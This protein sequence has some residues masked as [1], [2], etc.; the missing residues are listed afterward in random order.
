MFPLKDVIGYSSVWTQRFFIPLLCHAAAKSTE[1]QSG[2]DQEHLSIHMNDVFT[3]SPGIVHAI[4]SGCLIAEIQQSSNLTYRLYD[5]DRV[6]K[7]GQKREL[8]MGKALDVAD[9]HSSAVPRQPLRVLKYR[10]GAAT[11]LLAPASSSACG[12]KIPLAN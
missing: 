7:N 3:V 6:D 9:L 8:H 12:H 5:Y 2:A 4:G 10:S 11:E 1:Y